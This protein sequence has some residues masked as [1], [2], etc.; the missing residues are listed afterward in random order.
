MPEVQARIHEAGSFPVM[1][2]TTPEQWGEMFRR[3]VKTWADLVTRSGA[4][5]N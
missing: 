2:A 5:I 1:P 4:A 3:D